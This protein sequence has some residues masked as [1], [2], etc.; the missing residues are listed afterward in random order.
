M[1]TQVLVEM[2][3]ND[4]IYNVYALVVPRLFTSVVIG[5]NWLRENN[6]SINCKKSELVKIEMDK[7]VTNVG[8]QISNNVLRKQIEGAMEIKMRSENRQSPVIQLLQEHQRK[9]ERWGKIITA[10]EERRRSSETTVVYCIHQRILFAEKKTAR[11][12][13]VVCV[14]KIDIQSSTTD[15][16][17]PELPE[18]KLCWGI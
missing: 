5:L 18:C 10:I 13:W 16:C 4:D 3:W 12:G 15:R 7:E 6:I 2:K 11:N 17:T 14:L 9:D 1:K 8:K